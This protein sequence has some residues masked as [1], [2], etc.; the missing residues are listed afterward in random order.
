MLPDATYPSAW[1]QN[2]HFCARKARKWGFRRA[3]AHKNL[4]FVLERPE[5]EGFWG[6]KRTK[7]PILCSV[8]WFLVFRTQILVCGVLCSV[9]DKGERCTISGKIN[10]SLFTINRNAPHLCERHFVAVRT[11]LEP[12]T[13]CVTGMYSNQLNYRTIWR[14]FVI[15]SRY[16]S[17]LRVQ[18]YSKKSKPPNFSP[19]YFS[20]IFHHSVQNSD[21]TLI[22]K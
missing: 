17:R 11:G 9:D 3:K 13:P 10:L 21:K 14:S 20:K 15:C 2:P 8:S 6:Q 18:S 4:D 12:A 5:N 7:M 22:F 19:K 16:H 1:A